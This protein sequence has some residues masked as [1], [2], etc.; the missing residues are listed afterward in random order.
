MLDCVLS[1]TV[2][3][4]YLLVSYVGWIV[5]CLPWLCALLPCDNGLLDC[6]LC[7]GVFRLLIIVIGVLHCVMPGMV[8]LLILVLS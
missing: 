1:V 3:L 6:V 2:C 5:Y 4:F 7:Y 8:Y